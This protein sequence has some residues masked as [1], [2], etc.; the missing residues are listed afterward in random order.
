MFKSISSAAAAGGINAELCENFVWR[1]IK[2]RREISIYLKSNEKVINSENDDDD[3]ND[4]DEEEKTKKKRKKRSTSS[5]KKPPVQSFKADP[6]RVINDKASGDRGCSAE[7]FKRK[8]VDRW[9]RNHG[10]LQTAANDQNSR[11]YVNLSFRECLQ[12]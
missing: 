11:L 2:S 4:D 12:K 6:S 9:F 8:C 3:D 7:Y 1:L 10:Q 5:K